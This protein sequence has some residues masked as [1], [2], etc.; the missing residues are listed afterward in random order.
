MLLKFEILFSEV[1]WKNKTLEIFKVES[2][3]EILPWPADLT[4]SEDVV[5]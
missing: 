2:N 4:Q 1:Y 3:C 5:F